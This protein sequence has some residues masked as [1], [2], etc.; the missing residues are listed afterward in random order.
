MASFI[1]NTREQPPRRDKE[2]RARERAKAKQASRERERTQPLSNCTTRGPISGVSRQQPTFSRP[3]ASLNAGDCV[4]KLCAAATFLVRTTRSLFRFA[5]QVSH[6]S[7]YALE[8]Q[9]GQS[10]SLWC[11]LNKN[12]YTHA[13]QGDRRTSQKVFFCHS[14]TRTIFV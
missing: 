9:P 11:W 3:P 13:L 5:H 6:T 4:N 8:I 2:V 12:C 1:I 10:L 14:F 7:L